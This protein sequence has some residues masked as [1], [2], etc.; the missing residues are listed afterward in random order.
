MTAPKVSVMVPVYNVEKYFPR[1]IESIINQ[2]YTNLEILL[3]D[4]G[5]TDRSGFLCDEYA[6]K[7]ERIKVFHKEN[8][9]VSSARNM[10]L[11]NATGERLAF[12]DADDWIGSQYIQNLL[13]ICFDLIIGGYRVFDT[14]GVYSIIKL[15]QTNYNKD[16]FKVFLSEHLHRLYSH[17]PWGKIYKREI[18]EHYKLRYDVKVRVGEDYLFNLNYLLFCGSVQIVDKSEYYYFSNATM[19]ERYNLQNSEICYIIESLN[20]KIEQLNKIYNTNLIFS[21][22]TILAQYP[23]QKIYDEQND[24]DYYLLYKSFFMQSLKNDLYNDELCS[25][26]LNSIFMI[27]KHYFEKHYI[28]GKYLMKRMHNLYGHVYDSVRFTRKIDRVIIYL[29]KKNI[30]LSNM[31]LIIYSILKRFLSNDS[32]LI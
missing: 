19:S 20:T 8:G 4:D 10:G 12:I 13:N 32:R 29:L 18:V 30:N 11:D 17:V 6:A 3:V 26:I 31:F 7:D 28:Y 23:I 1:C 24:N 22:K 25:P 2:T 21:T 9:G 15:P 5:S 14:I 16:T 27:K